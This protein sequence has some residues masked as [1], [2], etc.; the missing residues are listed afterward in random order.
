MAGRLAPAGQ[1]AAGAADS[2]H[3]RAVSFADVLDRR[4]A[5]RR[6]AGRT[7]VPSRTAWAS[8]SAS[9]AATG[10]LFA[11]PLTAAVPRWLSVAGSGPRRPDHAFPDEE[12]RA[13]NRLLDLGAPRAN[14]S[15]D[16]LRREYRRLAQLFHPDRHSG[17]SV[18]EQGSLG[19]TFAELTERYR[20]LRAFVEPRH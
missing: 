6:R 12:R 18:V 3:V 19:R 11:R 9:S 10:F 20:C 14:F 17:G 7:A 16:D 8:G 1:A 13:F 4:S 2:E 5:R 15:A